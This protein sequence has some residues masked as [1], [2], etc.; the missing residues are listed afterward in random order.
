VNGPG[1]KPC[2]VEH[3]LRA[4]LGRATV[5]L[6]L[7]MALCSAVQSA[8]SPRQRLSNAK[9]GLF[10]HYVFGLTQA[11][12]GEPPLLDVNAFGDVLDVN[13]I[14]QMAKTMG[15]Q[16]VVFTSMHWRMTVLF[17][18]L[19]W[20]GLFPSHVTER[21]VNISDLCSTCIPTTG[22]TLPRRCCRS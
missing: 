1:M 16:Y 13:G 3:R 7:V 21:D 9:L 10:V 6:A 2:G 18:S 15:A 14:A 22:T 8:E 11:G 4:A 20:G 5:L 19:V 12:P 17:P